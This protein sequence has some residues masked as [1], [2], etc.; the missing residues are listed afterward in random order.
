MN[1][2]ANALMI[3]AMLTGLAACGPD[4]GDG[5]GISQKAAPDADSAKSADA[6]PVP[7]E[8]ARFLGKWTYVSGTY[9]I[10]CDGQPVRSTPATGTVTFTVGAAQDEIVASDGMG[11]DI[12][13]TVSGNVATAYRG[14]VCPGD[15]VV[16]SLVYTLQA[17]ALREQSSGNAPIEAQL[18]DISDDAMMARN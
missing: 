5:S 8:A 2:R 16:E 14:Y 17:G 13:C 1:T 7:T 3:F 9:T 6:A 10:A 18:C 12:P 15:L 11:C 4:G